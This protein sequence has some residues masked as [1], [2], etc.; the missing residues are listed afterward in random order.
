[1]GNEFKSSAIGKDSGVIRDLE[2]R[3]RIAR[4]RYNR[5]YHIHIH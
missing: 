5:K 3:I 2:R 1:M 4:A